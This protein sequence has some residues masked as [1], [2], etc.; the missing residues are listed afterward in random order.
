MGSGVA[1]VSSADVSIHD[2][3][4]EC[5]LL[6]MQCLSLSPRA[7]NSLMIIAV[8]LFAFTLCFFAMVCSSALFREDKYA[9]ERNSIVQDSAL[10]V[11]RG[12]LSFLF[13]EKPTKKRR[14]NQESQFIRTVQLSEQPIHPPTRLQL[15]E[16]ER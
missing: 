5:V 13:C 11:I 7:V 16:N 10:M 8:L 9:S 2:E 3:S 12:T 4:S 6:S 1:I 14:Q 15:L